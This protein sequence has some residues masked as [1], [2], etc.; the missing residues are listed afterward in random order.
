MFDAHKSFEDNLAAFKAACEAI[1][2]DCAKILFDNI[3]ILIE[4]GA[5]RSARTIFNAN[6]KAALDALPKAEEAQ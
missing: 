6:V 3:D 2:S 5:D 4:H 1:D